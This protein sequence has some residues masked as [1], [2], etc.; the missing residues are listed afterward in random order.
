MAEALEQ[1][2]FKLFSGG[3][4]LRRIAQDRGLSVERYQLIELGNL[5]RAEFGS[6]ILMRGA[7]QAAK[8]VDDTSNY[9]G[10][11]VDSLRNPAEVEFLKNELHA[12]VINVWAPDE[13]RFRWILDN[14]KPGDPENWY[15]FVGL[16]AIDRGVGQQA[17][18][19]NIAGC[20]ALADITIA[21]EGSPSDL[22][23]RIN[24]LLAKR[25]YLEGRPAG[26]ER[27]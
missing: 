27:R 20:V 23:Y 4:V 11:V 12:L 24:E 16:D 2:G 1:K 7:M 25:R 10:L 26:V 17:T 14:P 19:Q 22:E 9:K 6:D 15:E 13:T 8:R 5:L 18:G 3:D 21:N